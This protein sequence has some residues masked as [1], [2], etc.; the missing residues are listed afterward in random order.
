MHVATIIAS[1][2]SP[3]PSSPPEELVTP[4]PLGF[5]VIAIIAVIVVLL[6]LDMLRRIRRARYRS[7]VAEDLDLAEAQSGTGVEASAVDD[8]GVDPQDDPARR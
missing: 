3:A 4:G 1:A 7:E 6:A 8:Q 5:T 2:P